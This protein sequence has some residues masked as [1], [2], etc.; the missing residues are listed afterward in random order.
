MKIGTKTWKFIIAVILALLSGSFSTAKTPFINPTTTPIG[1]MLPVQPATISSTLVLTQSISSRVQPLSFELLGRPAAY[2]NLSYHAALWDLQHWHER[3]YLA[4]GD[5]YINSGP[6][7]MLYYD[8]KTGEFV[9]EDGFMV[10]EHGMEVFRIYEDMLIIPGIE[11]VGWEAAGNVELSS[12]YLKHWDEPWIRLNTIPGAVHIWDI[13]VLADILVAIGQ[14]GEFGGIWISSDGGLTWDDGPDFRAEGYSV[15]QSGFVLGDKLYVTTNG[16]G[17]LVFDGQAWGISDC[18]ASNIFEGTAA[19]QKNA[20][21]QGVV[22]MA[23]YW[24]TVD[25]RLHF[26]NGDSRWTVE[27]PDPVHDVIAAEES[28]FVLTGEP[29]GLGV[30]YVAQRLEYRCGG[31]FTRIVNLNFHDE[32]INLP[33]DEYMRQTVGSTPHA[34]EFANDRFYVGLADGRLF[35]SSPYQP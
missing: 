23:P 33:E 10:K 16:T 32:T 35:Q 34:L 29:S 28:L 18:L 2:R 15:T 9:Q 8:L 31:D 22:V 20:G 4:H 12:L 25:H 21:F 24:V 27:F 19:I 14:R 3:I 26:F 30:I 13:A 1:S 5:W 7:R 11:T 17:C 6:L